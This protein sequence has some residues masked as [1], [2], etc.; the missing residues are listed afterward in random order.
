MNPSILYHIHA[1]YV[2][3]DRY[4]ELFSSHAWW[5]LVYANHIDEVLKVAKDMENVMSV[6]MYGIGNNEQL[7]I[8]IVH[9]YKIDDEDVE[10]QQLYKGYGGM[11][12]A[13]L[14]YD[15]KRYKATTYELFDSGTV[16]HVMTLNVRRL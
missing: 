7:I 12:V 13:S 16:Y 11:S 3:C 15:K 1:S 5:S 9:N 4:E 6:E 10:I 2:T 8:A 14:S